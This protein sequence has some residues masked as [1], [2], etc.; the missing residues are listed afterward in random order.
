MQPRK[1]FANI[2]NCRDI[3][4]C[5]FSLSDFEIEVYRSAAS[6]GPIRADDL[7]DHMRRDRS[8]VYRALQRLLACEMV[9]R[10][11]R[12]LNKGGYYHVYTGIGRDELRAKLEKCIEEWT[13]RMQNALNNFDE[14]I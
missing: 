2:S 7:A 6:H 12:S 13:H 3:I 8:T 5:A 1:S 9:Y 10:E 11:A 4:Q 14:C